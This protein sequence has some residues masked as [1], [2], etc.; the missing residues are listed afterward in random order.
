MGNGRI[1]NF[2]RC[3]LSLTEIALELTYNVMNS[4]VTA[5]PRT[6]DGDLTIVGNWA[7]QDGTSAYMDNDNQYASQRFATLNCN[8]LQ[9]VLKLGDKVKNPSGDVF[10]IMGEPR[11]SAHGKA[12]Y[13]LSSI[14]SIASGADR[15]LM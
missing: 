1:R 5:I 15:G 6:Y 2:M 7:E 8:D 14:E 13:T 9:P 12:K 4:S 3:A 11:I 10:F